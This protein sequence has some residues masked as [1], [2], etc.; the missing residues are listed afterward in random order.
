MS[1][2]VPLLNLPRIPGLRVPPLVNTNVGH[3]TDTRDAHKIYKTKH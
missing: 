3:A 2:S 1:L